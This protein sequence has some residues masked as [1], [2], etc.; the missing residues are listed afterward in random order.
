MDLTLGCSDASRLAWVYGTTILSTVCDVK[1]TLKLGQSQLRSKN[2]CP[3]NS[4]KG[5][6]ARSM[7]PSRTALHSIFVSLTAYSAILFATGH[8]RLAPQNAV[9]PTPDNIAMPCRCRVNLS[10][11]KPNVFNQVE[12]DDR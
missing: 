4:L 2:R 3:V 12:H 10:D 1:R 6:F 7:P 9:F 5:D 8:T 11:Q